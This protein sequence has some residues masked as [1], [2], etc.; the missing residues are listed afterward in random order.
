VRTKRLIRAR[1]LGKL[2]VGFIW[3][4]LTLPAA[5]A[6]VP[7]K[8]TSDQPPRKVIVATVMQ[9]FWGQYPGLQNAW[10]N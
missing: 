6:G 2:V 8:S 1:I 9:P 3:F 4:L 5:G 7:M 10:S